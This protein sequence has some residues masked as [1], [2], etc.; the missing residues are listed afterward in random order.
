MYWSLACSTE[1]LRLA[2][3]Q[4][5]ADAGVEA[6][7]RLAE[8]LVG[9]IDVGLCGLDELR[10]GLNVEDGVANLRVHLLHLVG[11][12]VAGLRNLRA[13]DV[14]LA[15]RLGDLQNGR[16]DA[17]GCAVGA[18]RVVGGLADVSEVAGELHGGKLAGAG[19]V[20]HGARCGHLLVGRG[21][22]LAVLQRLRKRSCGIEVVQR[23]VGLAV[24]EADKPGRAAARWRAPAPACPWPTGWLWR[25]APAA[26][27]GSPP[28]RA[29]RRAAD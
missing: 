2:D 26:R 9:Q 22:V 11:Q 6:L 10:G 17:A 3:G 8:R 14:L 13:G 24:G 16:G 27:S 15:A 7:L 1:D 20:L 4:V 5:V 18:V 19:R 29:E 12:L 21:Q 28:A 25:S 23:G